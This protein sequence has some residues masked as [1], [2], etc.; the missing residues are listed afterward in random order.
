MSL[1]I[2]ASE[3]DGAFVACDDSAVCALVWTSF[4]PTGVVNNA[5][6]WGRTLSPL[7]ELSPIRLLREDEGLGDFTPVL[8][9]NPGFVLFGQRGFQ[10]GALGS[11]SYSEKLDAQGGFVLGPFHE[12]A[13][14]G[15]PDSISDPGD[16]AAIPGGFVEVG[17]GFDQ[18]QDPCDFGSCIGVFLYFFDLAGNKLRDRVQV[19][20]D[21][22]GW[23]KYLLNN[24][25]VNRNGTISVGFYRA[26]GPEGSSRAFFRRFSPTG[27]PLGG[28]VEVGGDLPGRQL[29]TV[30]AGAPGGQVAVAWLS[31]ADPRDDF[32]EI[33]AQQ[34]DADGEPLGPEQLVSD[35]FPAQSNA[36]IA[37]DSQGN[38]FIMW[39]SLQEYGFD[40][41][42][43]LYHHDGRPVAKGFRINQDASFD[44]LIGL[45]AFAP[46]GT[47]TA[48]YGTNDPPL[49]GGEAGVPVIRRY[50][51]SPGQEVCTIAGAQIGCDLARTGGP[52]E[53][54]LS[55]GGRPGEVTLFGDVDADGR[56]DVCS[57]WHGR[58][59]C[60]VSHEGG[61][62]GWVE[63]FGSPGDVPLLADV[64]GDGRAD[65]CLRRKRLLLCDTVGDGQAHHQV[66]FGRGGELPLLGDLDGDG[67]ADLCLVSGRSWE[68]RLASGPALHFTFGHRGDAPALGDL[69]GDRRADP[70]VLRPG[71][72]LQCA[73]HSLG[74]PPDSTLALQAPAGARPLFGNLDGL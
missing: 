5:R 50:A 18:P 13:S 28:E 57:Y 20:E 54:E 21:S 23:E 71:G 12:P 48:T 7:G 36:T 6:Q 43:R 56:D 33:Y 3:Q 19:N 59:R 17:N 41:R 62:P 25:A 45:A 51:A 35:P 24:L 37:M 40:A 74:G 11:W 9:L 42:G 67:R 10:T 44:Q 31:I 34:F 39:N 61:P 29:Y 63:A 15:D 14:F 1:D 26:T 52:A 22:S 16:V 55:R 64:D 30:L 46:N 53:L 68:C 4:K 66:S 72:R 2:D 73:T 27:E 49:T 65:P 69:D 47:L 58:F 8:P 32:G 70:C 38:Y 60:D